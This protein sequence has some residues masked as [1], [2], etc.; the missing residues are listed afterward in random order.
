MQFILAQLLIL[1]SLISCG[2]ADDDSSRVS[3]PQGE[4]AGVEIILDRNEVIWGFEFL[5]DNRVIFTERSGRILISDMEGNTVVAG[6]PP[7]V[8]PG[9]EAGLLD[10]RLRGSEVYYCYSGTAAGGR[11]QALGRATLSGNRLINFQRIFSAGGASNATTHFGCRIEFIG[12]NQLLL[13]VG[14]QADSSRA[15]NP[16]SLQGKI[17]SMNLD[18]TNP[19]IWSSGHR[20]PQGL[21]TNPDTGEIFSAEHGPTGGDELNIIRQGQNYGWPGLSGPGFAE[22]II[23][24]TPAIA[25]SGIAFHRGALYIA[26]LRGRHIRKLILSGED[27]VSE[28]LLFRNLDVRFRN[29]RSGPDGRLYFSTDDGKFGRIIQ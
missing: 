9:G 17:L 27:V 3:V 2:N 1:L 24:W 7:D 25:P 11:T 6:S 13:S 10:L 29:V 4:E 26:T 22:P 12:S 14:D 15:Q 19:Q 5:P 21:A 8:A 28:E 16:T 18:G 23:S 20:N